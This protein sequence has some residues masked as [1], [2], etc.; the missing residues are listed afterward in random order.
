MNTSKYCIYRITNL[1]NGKT[2]IGQ[3]RYTKLNDNYKGSGQLLWK[4]YEKYGFEN[5]A[6]EVL[7]EVEPEGQENEE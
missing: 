2:Y 3:H 6:K 4:A 1:I 5:F 7:E